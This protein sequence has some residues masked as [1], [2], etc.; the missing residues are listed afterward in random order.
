MRVL[1]RAQVL[2][3]ISLLGGYKKGSTVPAGLSLFCLHVTI[4][5]EVRYNMAFLTKS[6]INVR[7]ISLTITM[8]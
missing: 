5:A 2:L 6:E 8:V 4:S 7:E 3:I 1:L